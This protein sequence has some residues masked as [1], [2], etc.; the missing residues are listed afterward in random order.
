MPE[1]VFKAWETWREATQDAR[2]LD[3][4]PRMFQGPKAATDI[5]RD[6]RAVMRFLT[7][8]DPSSVMHEGAHIFMLDL[9]PSEMDAVHRWLTSEVKRW[10]GQDISKLDL[11]ENRLVG[12]SEAVRQG[13]EAFARGFEKYMA[14]G[15]A[16]SEGLKAVFEKFK[17]WLL[18]VYQ[19]IVGSGI[20][21][22]LSDAMRQLYGD[23]LGGRA[24][25]F[26]IANATWKSIEAD[27]VAQGRPRT[28]MARA[29]AAPEIVPPETITPPEP[30]VRIGGYEGA[31][32]TARGPDPGV[33]YRFR[34]RIMD[35]DEPLVSHDLSGNM[36]E[37]YPKGMQP[38]DRTR[39][40]SLRQS[41]D[42]AEKLNP[43]ALL[44]HSARIDDG[45]PI[46]ESSGVVSSGNGRMNGLRIAARDLPQNYAAYRRAL[47]DKVRAG[48][49]G[50]MP[51]DQVQQIKRPV[52]VRENLEPAR[53]QEIAKASLDS[54][55]MGMSA[56]EQAAL[57]VSRITES[58]LET[59]VINEGQAVQD[60]LLAM[61]NRQIVRDFV[62]QLPRS[63]Q[64]EALTRNG[65]PTR[66][67]M[68]RMLAA[69][70]MFVYGDAEAPDVRL[71]LAERI[72]E[73]ADPVLKNV[74]GAMM[75]VA[76]DMAKAEALIRAN[77]R[78]A[79][80]S[81]VRELVSAVEELVRIKEDPNL[82]VEDYLAQGLLLG[83]ARAGEADLVRSIIQTFEQQK[84]SMKAIREVLQGYARA[85][86]A[87]PE[88]GQMG[89][90]GPH[91]Y[92]TRLGLWQRVTEAPA[93]EAT[94]FQLPEQMPMRGYFDQTPGIG[95]NS[96]R[97][98][99][100]YR[101]MLSV[102]DEL[103]EQMGDGTGQEVKSE[104]VR[105]RLSED[106]KA[107]FRKWVKGLEGKLSGTK[108]SAVKWGEDVRNFS[109]LDYTAL[110]GVDTHF[111]GIPF[112]YAFWPTR[113]V[114]RHLLR[115]IDFPALMANYARLNEARRKQEERPGFPSRLKGKVYIPI[116]WMPEW[117]GDGLWVDPIRQFFPPAMFL[118]SFDRIQI[119]QNRVGKRTEYI[120]QKWV[121]SGDTT[122]EDAQAAIQTQSGELWDMAL[123]QAKTEL[124]KEFQDPLDYV[125][126]LTGLSLPVS[127]AH[128]YLRGTP[129]R[130]QPLPLTRWTKTATSAFAQWTGIG[131]PEGV[132]IEGPIREALDLP[133]YD[134]FEDYRVDRM[135]STM[136]AEDPSITR[137]A[138]IEGIEKS[139]SLYDEATR[140]VNAARNFGIYANPLFFVFGLGGDTFPDGEARQ[141]KLSEEFGLAITARD[142]GDSTALNRFF[143]KYPEYEGRLAS[144]DTPEERFRSF[145]ID[146][147]WVNYNQLGSA[148]K[149]LARNQLGQDFQELFLSKETRS[150]GDVPVETLAAWA[151]VIGGYVPENAPNRI[152]Y[153]ELLPPLLQLPPE[154][155]G[156]IDTF[157]TERNERFPN[158]F[159]VQQGYFTS[160]PSRSAARE[161]YL[162]QWPEL[163]DYWDWR[164]DQLD[165]NDFLRAYYE[166]YD[167]EGDQ[168][169]LGSLGVPDI[170]TNPI[171]MRQ[172]LA[173]EFGGQP[174]TSGAL[175][176]LR[177]I[178]DMMGSGTGQS[179]LEWVDGL[180]VEGMS[181]QA[182]APGGGG[183]QALP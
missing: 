42:I 53:G 107:E 96:A 86:I 39:A 98:A 52:L 59:L 8:P 19:A 110:R 21:V 74:T 65:E 11:M 90:L 24:P 80:L 132:N 171:L 181:Q 156:V 88:T 118:D 76:G 180:D 43:P 113:Q 182:P 178:Y 102:M 173:S 177:R 29:E 26:D 64:A 115:F 134:R 48:E 4:Q 154:A 123:E 77:R 144:F 122:P 40:A 158:W 45:S 6:G 166:R 9:L 100:G 63:E 81:I 91:E 170:V 165:G 84:R 47:V 61:S 127:I 23:I 72:F 106:Q 120:L 34:Y 104:D 105:N 109:L 27:A 25:D 92:P 159:A 114:M 46:I 183:Y 140:R 70:F 67:V 116:P 37:G 30:N 119:E 160:G 135:L 155:A 41:Q 145:L 179:F 130:I 69:M 36:T 129:E 124:Q 141:R 82:S 44:D 89:L 146:E 139:G 93:S 60:A 75:A 137:Q 97:S 55:V 153:K 16:P 125:Q 28:P 58:M 149:E 103:R 101:N 147:V 13:Y 157:R 138:L 3:Q 161:E 56:I 31:E 167:L 142:L 174:L 175:E 54:G 73:S 18:S 57:D 10:G 7:N 17:Q 169:S 151:H 162:G 126:L 112:N 117:M 5:G 121:E 22:P 62:K 108:F 78:P 95:E 85:V 79:G 15:V 143:E 87:E 128:E 164:D 71:R 163:Q 131:N 172:L 33:S 168:G 99:E 12:R 51:L 2:W 49:Y 148:N 152:E 32:N 133:R 68:D 94:L 136:M 66:Q 1:P 83:F 50:P 35:L 176:E 20:D 150:Y 111:L 14:E 38:R